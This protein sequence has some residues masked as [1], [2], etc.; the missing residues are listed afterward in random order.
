MLVAGLIHQEMKEAVQDMKMSINDCLL[1]G[2]FIKAHKKHGK[3]QVTNVKKR[4]V[5]LFKALNID[6]TNPIV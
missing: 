2:C 1:S 6:L 5:E 3:W 4:Y